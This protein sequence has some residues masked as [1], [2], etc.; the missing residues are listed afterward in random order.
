MR[1][2]WSHL[3]TY[4]D[5]GYADIDNNYVER[6]IRPFTTGR[7][8]WLFADTPAGAHASA[9]LYSLVE[10]AKANKIDPYQYL[11][12]VFT[13]LPQIAEGDSIDHLLPWNLISETLN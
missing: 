1:N 6:A 9:A 13:E 2:A 3:T 12:R 11:K 7:K 4:V 8:N 10:T 5:C